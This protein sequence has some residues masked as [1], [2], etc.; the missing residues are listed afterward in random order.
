MHV[1]SRGGFQVV[2]STY[3]FQFKDQEYGFGVADAG[4]AVALAEGWTN[5]PALQSSTVNSSGTSVPIP[6]APDTGDP[7]T[8]VSASLHL[9]A[10]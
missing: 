1:K 5:A 6:D 4:T 9:I 2:A 10:A 8:V 3:V 7:T